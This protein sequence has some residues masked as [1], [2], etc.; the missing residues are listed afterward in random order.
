VPVLAGTV[1]GPL[2]PGVAAPAAVAAGVP[3]DDGVPVLVGTVVGRLLPGMVAPAAVATGAPVDAVELGGAPVPVLA[4]TV[5][6]PLLPG[7]VA[8]AAVAAGAPVTVVEPDG[9]PVPVLAKLGADGVPG[10]PVMRLNHFP[11]RKTKLF[12]SPTRPV[13]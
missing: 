10:A 4:G 1:A 11:F 6:G 8:P 3:V 13:P 7:A 5:T 12:S 9:V 2:L